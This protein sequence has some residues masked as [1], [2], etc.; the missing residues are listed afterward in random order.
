MPSPPALALAS[1]QASGFPQ[2]PQGEAERSHVRR[3]D[4]RGSD[5]EEL[6]LRA[7]AQSS[8]TCGVRPGV[9]RSRGR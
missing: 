5:T 9:A 6:T 1:P 2:L 4:L 8:S 7:A 3:V